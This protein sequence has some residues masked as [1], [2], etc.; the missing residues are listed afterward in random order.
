MTLDGLVKEAELL[1]KEPELTREYA[2]NLNRV[3]RK[4]HHHA[5]NNLDSN[6]YRDLNGCAILC[7]FKAGKVFFENL[8]YLSAAKAFSSAG[9]YASLIN[10][11]EVQA[12]C[13]DITAKF[14]LKAEYFKE[15]IYAFIISAQTN[16][17]IENALGSEDNLDKRRQAILEA[18]HQ[19]SQV[20]ELIEAHSLQEVRNNP[21]YKRVF[22][23]Y[24]V[25]ITLINPSEISPK[26]D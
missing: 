3:G 14:F 19:F 22:E 4:L 12:R 10:K 2:E 5:N 21:T 20:E 9:H 16:F 26:S 18:V 24:S 15:A 6:L 8:E 17:K 11:L 23:K 25:A 7:R 1:L 13:S